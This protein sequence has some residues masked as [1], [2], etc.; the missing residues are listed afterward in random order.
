MTEETDLRKIAISQETFEKLTEDFI[1]HLKNEEKVQLII[2]GNSDLHPSNIQHLEV[3][4]VILAQDEAEKYK[5]ELEMEEKIIEYQ[6]MSSLGNIEKM[7]EQM[8]LLNTYTPERITL[9]KKQ[10]YYVPRT[11]G[12]PNPKKKGGR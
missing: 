6:N 3:S 5:K 11:I 12:K 1:E 4:G 10:K 2:V 7:I 8:D 9:P